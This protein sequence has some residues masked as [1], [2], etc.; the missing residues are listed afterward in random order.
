MIGVLATRVLVGA[1]VTAGLGA[2]AAWLWKLKPYTL[3][4]PRWSSAQ[5]A[6]AKVVVRE[7]RAAGLSDAEVAA[8]LVNARAESNLDPMAKGDGGA[9]IGLFQLNTHGAGAGYSANQRM[10]PQLNTRIMLEREVLHDNGRSFRRMADL[11]ASVAVLAGIFAY[12]LERPRDREGEKQRRE[13]LAVDLFGPAARRPGFL[14]RLP[15]ELSE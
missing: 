2:A 4:M 8:M 10:D 9:S 5:R 14:V 7:A 15:P 12:D 3:T 13:Q 1:G 11:G 6:A